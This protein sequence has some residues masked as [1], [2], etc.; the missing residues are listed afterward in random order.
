MDPSRRVGSCLCG[1]I[2][3]EVDLP[4]KWCA[5]CHCTMC[6]RAHGAAYVT[7]FGVDVG[8]FRV[9]AGAGELLRYASSPG[10]SRSFCGRCGSSLFFESVR[11]PGEIHVVLANLHGELDRAPQAHVFWETHVPWGI[12]GDE[13][14]RKTSRPLP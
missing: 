6:R 10:A 3:F 8:Q 11:W 7:W 2:T 4:S 14:P 13:L 12:P 5:H 1:A 9:T